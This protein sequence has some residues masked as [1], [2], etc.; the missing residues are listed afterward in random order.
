VRARS[1]VLCL[2]VC[3]VTALTLAGPARRPP[4][5]PGRWW[6]RVSADVKR[7][8]R[9]IYDRRARPKPDDTPLVRK[10]RYFCPH[11]DRSP[12]RVRTFY[13]TPRGVMDEMTLAVY[14]CEIEGIYWTHVRGGI[15]GF[16]LVTG[17]Y[18]LGVGP[19]A[20]RPATRPTTRPAAGALRLR[21]ERIG[22][23]KAVR[24]GTPVDIAVVLVNTGRRPI[25]VNANLALARLSLDIRGPRVQTEPAPARPVA[26]PP[27][28]SDFVRLEPGAGH[29]IVVRNLTASR[30]RYRLALHGTYLIR[31]TYRND[32]DGS[33]L[34][35]RA[36][37]GSVTS[38]SLAVRVV[39]Q[40]R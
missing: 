38:N 6:Q 30:Y 10:G 37:T 5:E 21:I 17:P 28:R 35:I 29:R 31:V 7:F 23:R 24:A 16:N 8:K 14:Y 19:A 25:H 26:D 20:T 2:V 12:L 40:S 11:E 39:G 1:V 4:R 15:A 3:A 36:W 18:R 9:P 33:G 27:R 22:V 32:H 34:G 13:L